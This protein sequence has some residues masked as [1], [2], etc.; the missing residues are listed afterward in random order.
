MSTRVEQLLAHKGNNVWSVEPDSSVQDAIT[1][2]G[3]HE[4]GAVLVCDK[5]GLLGILSE[6]DC[7]R[8]ILWQGRSTLA[9]RVRDVMRADVTAVSPRDSIEH[10]MGLMTDRRTRHLPVIDQ[11]TVI[12]VI[13][14]GD[15][16]NGLLG[17]KES[18]IESLESYI[19]GSPSVR[20]PAH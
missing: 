4:I 14:I 11:S 6:R 8:K 18:L 9:S 19:S 7:V 16:I 5:H 20:P 2:F 13:S 3:T 15:V 17:E 12:G 1:L 10:C